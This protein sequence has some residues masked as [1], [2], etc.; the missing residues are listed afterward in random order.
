LAIN[1]VIVYLLVS[2]A[3]V[4]IL[5]AQTVAAVVIAYESYY[6]YQSLARR[7]KVKVAVKVPTSLEDEI[8]YYSEDGEKI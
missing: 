6:A 5:T 4:P 7:N 3:G 8:V 1:T 2:G